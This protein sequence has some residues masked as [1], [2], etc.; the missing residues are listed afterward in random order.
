[1]TVQMQGREIIFLVTVIFFSEP[2]REFL[3]CYRH[4]KLFYMQ[5]MYMF[6]HTINLI[7]FL[8]SVHSFLP[9]LL[10]CSYIHFPDCPLNKIALVNTTKSSPLVHSHCRASLYQSH[11]F[12]WLAYFSAVRW[13]Q[14]IPHKCLCLFTQP[15]SNTSQK[16][17]LHSYYLISYLRSFWRS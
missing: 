6:Y 15:H 12:P 13:W 7:S 10:P 2:A 9:T 1:M 4:P 16:I 3:L 8:F 17:S 5:P 11:I 14:H